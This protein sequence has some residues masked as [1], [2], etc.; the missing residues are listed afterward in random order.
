MIET[1]TLRVGHQDYIV[2]EE[3]ELLRELGMLGRCDKDRGLILYSSDFPPEQVVDSLLHE[4]LHAIWYCYLFEVEV[5]EEQ[6]VTMLAHGLT[7]VMR[8]NP[9][10]FEELQ[11]LVKDEVDE[12]TRE[13]L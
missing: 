7:Q 6:A 9:F 11:E 2:R 8:D 12:D 10:F 13:K 1:E 3:N 5:E 4:M